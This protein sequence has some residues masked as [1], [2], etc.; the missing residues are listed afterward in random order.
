MSEA[1]RGI[2]IIGQSGGPTAVINESLVG[3]ALEARKYPQIERLWGARHGVKGI[4]EDKL[5]D[6]SAE[7]RSNLLEVAATPSAALGSARHKP[8][9]DDCKAILEVFRKR[10]V[11]YFF[12]IGGND[13]AE[14]A[15]I[16]SRVARD[17][18]YDLRVVHLPKTVDN[19]LVGHDHC[20]GYGSAARFVAQA[21][22]GDGC[23]NASLPGV[24]V[25]ILMGRHAGFLT[26]ASA[27]A[28]EYKDDSPHLIYLPERGV[29]AEKLVADVKKV[30]DRLGRCV[31]AVSEG[32]QDEKGQLYAEKFLSEVDSHGNKQ[33]S[34]SG[35]LGDY[36]VQLLKD[37]LGNKKLRARSDTFGYLQ[38]S[39]AGCR[40]D[41]DA[42]EARWSGEWGVAQAVLRGEPASV[43]IVR[44][45]GSGYE[46]DLKLLPL[47]SVAQKTRH[48]PA[49]WI[50]PDG[51]D[52]T[53]AFLEYAR[54][55]VGPLP[56]MGRLKFH[57]VESAAPATPAGVS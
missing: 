51:N 27:L 16:V 32:V 24:K 39:Y 22:M 57:K 2:A 21:F 49:E 6:L 35:A 42:A 41:V 4:L 48:M 30:Y 28:R 12:Y 31:L 36:I 40:S 50:S 33:L 15:D 20:P 8:T 11:R 44:R 19:D 38:R 55:L 37:G 53:E 13:S 54:P 56:H 43:A 17:N 5:V 25:N 14:T 7:T 3:A 26:A 29:S 47:E 9:P 45:S 52:V 18:S 34:G 23:D 46:A 10:N 1:P